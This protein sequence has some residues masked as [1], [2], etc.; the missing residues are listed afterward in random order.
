MIKN[1]LKIALRNLLR[2]KLYSFLNIGGLALG[3][4]ASILILLWVTNE[5]SYNKFNKRLDRIFLVPQTQ[6]YQTIGDF[7][8]QPTPMPLAQR[9][10]DDNPQVE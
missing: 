10:K 6:H 1:Y 9:L 7:T 4:A 8:V 2:N 5:V 3:M